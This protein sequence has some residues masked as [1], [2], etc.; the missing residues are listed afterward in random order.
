ML[1]TPRKSPAKDDEEK[2]TERE[3]DRPKERKERQSHWGTKVGGEDPTALRQDEA[4]VV[5]ALRS[6]AWSSLQGNA[7]KESQEEEKFDT[8]QSL[9]LMLDVD[10]TFMTFLRAPRPG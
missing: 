10:S 2:T 9:Q 1:T 8:T 6:Q 7:K 3:S 5:H 4:E